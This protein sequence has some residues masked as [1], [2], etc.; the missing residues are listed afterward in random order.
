MAYRC[1]NRFKDKNNERGIQLCRKTD[2]G[3]IRQTEKLISIP[4]N[5]QKET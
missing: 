2:G 5:A 1:K 3:E 4:N